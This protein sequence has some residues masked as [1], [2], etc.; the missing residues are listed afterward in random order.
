MSPPRSKPPVS[1]HARFTRVLRKYRGHIFYLVSQ[2]MH[3]PTW[4]DEVLSKVSPNGQSSA[5]AGPP[6]LYDQEFGQANP[7]PSRKQD[8][9]DGDA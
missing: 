4:A 3:Q 2:V 8:S 6:M 7:P 5:I 1:A 9:I